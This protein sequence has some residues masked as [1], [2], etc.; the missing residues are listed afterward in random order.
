MMR[1]VV[2]ILIVI[3]LALVPIVEGLYEVLVGICLTVSLILLF[4][5]FVES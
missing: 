5:I 4:I 1:A 2:F 3:V